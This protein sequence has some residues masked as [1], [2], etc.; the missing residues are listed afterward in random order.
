MKCVGSDHSARH[1]KQ[2]ADDLEVDLLLID[3]GIL[4][5]TFPSWLLV[6]T[7]ATEAAGM[8]RW[9]LAESCYTRGPTRWKRVE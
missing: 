5:F 2:R 8:G 6:A 1:M 9:A 3:T 4:H 7:K